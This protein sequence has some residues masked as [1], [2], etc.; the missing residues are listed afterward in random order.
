MPESSSASAKTS[1]V[2]ATAIANRRLR[3]AKSR[4]LISHTACPALLAVI[5]SW[6]VSRVT[7]RRFERPRGTFVFLLSES[8]LFEG[9]PSAELESALGG[10]ARRRVPGGSVLI[11]ED[12]YLAEMYVL[13]SGTAE[14]AVRGSDGRTEVV[15][16]VGPGET[17]GEMALLTREPASATVR[18]VDDVELLVLGADD[19]AEL[20]ERIPAVPRN[21][22]RILSTRLTRMTRLS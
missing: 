2:A 4:T 1:P 13:R 19:L 11:A 10:F 14:I 6:E 12:D 9:V 7:Q 18:A 16:R 17:I 22:I 15:S 20:M 21:I 3:Q 5:A 8:P